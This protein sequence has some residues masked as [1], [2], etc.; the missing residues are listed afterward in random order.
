MKCEECN[1][2]KD[3]KERF[4]SCVRCEALSEAASSLSLD[5]DEKKGE[6]DANN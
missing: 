1:L 4:A 5:E 2:T 6:Q 3:F